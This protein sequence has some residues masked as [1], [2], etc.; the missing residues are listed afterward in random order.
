MKE[1]TLDAGGIRFRVSRRRIRN[2]NLYVKPPDGRV[3]ISAPLGVSDETIAAFVRQKAA[4]IRSKQAALRERIPRPPRRWASGET[5]FLWGREYLLRVEEGKW[6]LR[7]E[8]EE[9]L[10]TVKPGSTAEERE[11]WIREWYRDCMIRRTEILLPAWSERTGLV[12]SSWQ[13]KYMK[14][15]WGSCNTVTGKIW[16]NPR[17]AA[18]PPEC[19]DYVILHELAHLRVRDHGPDFRA[20][21]DRFMPGWKEIRRRLNRSGTDP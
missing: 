18:K 9:I 4:W 8:G 16:L 3:E 5:L 20:I 2:I 10:F 6:S 21:L 13:T 19:L 1:K 17:L 7:P 12:P 11:A 15:R 14:T